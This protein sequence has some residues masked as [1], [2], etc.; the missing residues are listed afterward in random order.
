MEGYNLTNIEIIFWVSLILS[1]GVSLSFN[2]LLN[3]YEDK[4]KWV[5]I[6]SK[7]LES[8]LED[9]DQLGKKQEVESQVRS[10]WDIDNLSRIHLRLG[11]PE[12]QWVKSTRQVV[13]KAE[14]CCC[15]GPITAIFRSMTIK[16][17]LQQIDDVESKPT[18]HHKEKMKK[19][20]TFICLWR[21]QDQ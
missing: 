21:V 19:P 5:K 1:L 12:D 14:G 11:N 9:H 8:L 15:W 13:S 17:V 3:K 4:V 20:K 7:S 16:D 6:K 2:Y 18:D 10:F